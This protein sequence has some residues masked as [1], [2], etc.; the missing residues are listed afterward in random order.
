MASITL[1][2]LCVIVYNACNLN[3]FTI[4]KT[5]YFRVVGS[6]TCLFNNVFSVKTETLCSGEIAPL[7][8]VKGCRLYSARQ[9]IYLAQSLPPNVMR[10]QVDTRN[11]LQRGWG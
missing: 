4:S 1:V 8:A 3:L 10:R 7:T 9:F 2:L 6:A 5:S 11:S